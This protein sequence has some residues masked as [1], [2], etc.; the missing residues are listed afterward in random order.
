MTFPK[1]FITMNVFFWERSSH[2]FYPTACLY[3][4][5][6]GLCDYL[7]NANK[8]IFLPCYSQSTFNIWIFFFVF[9]LLF[10]MHRQKIWFNCTERK[11]WRVRTTLGWWDYISFNK[12]RYLIRILAFIARAYRLLPVGGGNCSW[13]IAMWFKIRRRTTFLEMS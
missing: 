9:G 5:C 10:T 6:S 11:I 7:I 1:G 13:R 4:W 12:W 2:E 8:K 3:I